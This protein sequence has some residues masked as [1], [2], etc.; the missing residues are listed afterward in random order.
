VGHPHQLATG[1][2]RKLK[3]AMKQRLIHRFGQGK[4]FGAELL[5]L[6]WN[7]YH[8][9]SLGIELALQ[10]DNQPIGVA[11]Y[12]GWNDYF[13]PFCNTIPIQRF[14]NCNRHL[15]SRLGA[16]RKT[17]FRALLDNNIH[18]RNYYLFDSQKLAQIHR[19]RIHNRK[20]IPDA[21]STRNKLFQD[22]ALF[23]KN[24]SE[25]INKRL[26]NRIHPDRNWITIH[27]RRGDKIS[28]H[29][30]ASLKSYR[31]TLKQIDHWHSRPI[32]VMSDDQAS[33]EKLQRLL[34]LPISSLGSTTQPYPNANGYVQDDFNAAEPDQRL[35]IIRDLLTELVIATS[36]GDFIGTA[37][38]NV[39]W[40][41]KLMS[42]NEEI[43]Y[44]NVDDA[45][46]LGA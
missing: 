37:T 7:Y 39:F 43:K 36:S 28:E 44:W 19:K 27:I 21:I 38:S 23:N 26:A 10:Q 9:H 45:A 20:P 29:S 35:H 24:T 46:G 11:C 41:V 22:V 32:Y 40:I 5:D 33:I 6:A 17:V 3:A 31:D 2:A 30:Y 15:R 4:G 12:S 14:A 18:S 42:T 1:G 13:Q 16:P 25:H 8:C 34:D